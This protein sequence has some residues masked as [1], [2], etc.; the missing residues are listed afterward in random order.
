[1]GAGATEMSGRLVL[2]GAVGLAACALV[3]SS[4]ED[5]R[6]SE[7]ETIQRSFN[8]VKSADV[9]NFDG[10]IT[11]AGADRGDIEMEVHKTIRARSQEKIEEAKREVRLDI[12][13]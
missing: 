5:L 8:A 4:D 6:L 11:V 2:C 1:M 12:A 10:S 13:Q 3:W 9:D 7:N